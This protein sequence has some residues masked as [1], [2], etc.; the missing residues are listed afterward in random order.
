MERSNV[1]SSLEHA[2]L[3]V[4]RRQFGSK[5]EDSVKTEKTIYLAGGALL[6]LWS[7]SKINFLGLLGA[8]AGG[9]LI[10]RGATG[11][12]PGK[13]KENNALS[14]IDLHSSVKINKPRAELYAYWR[15]LENLPNFMS[16]IKHIKEVD[17]KRSKWTAEIPGGVGTIEWDAEIIREEPDHVIAWQS[18]PDAEI[19]NSGEVRFEEIAGGKT[20]VETTI[21]YRPPAGEIGEMAAKLL[22]PAFKKVIKK[23]LKQ[24]KKVMEKGGAVKIQSQINSRT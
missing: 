12:W 9:A 6:S 14:E 23:D 22:N 5:N 11:K 10:Y 15:N 3:S 2:N 4:T 18:L 16:H 24:F 13:E 20:K 19:E 1:N 8:A 17:K 7:I 21:I